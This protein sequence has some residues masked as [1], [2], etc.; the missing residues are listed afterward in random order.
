M[1]NFSQLPKGLH[2]VRSAGSEL[3]NNPGDCSAREGRSARESAPLKTFCRKAEPKKA[4]QVI[5]PCRLMFNDRKFSVQSRSVEQG[6]NH[7]I[8]EVLSLLG[9]SIGNLLRAKQ[10]LGNSDA[11]GTCNVYAVLF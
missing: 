8:R 2:A 3:Q 9:V 6:S 4:A 7:L 10:T 11:A 5:N 1:A